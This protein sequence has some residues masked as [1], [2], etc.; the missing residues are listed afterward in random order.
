MR[1]LNLESPTARNA[2]VRWVGE[3]RAVLAGDVRGHVALE[4]LSSLPHLYGLGPLEGLRGE[5]SIFGDAPSLAHVE[6]GR[7][8]TA[9]GWNA[10]SCFLVWA[11][12]PQ[13]SNH[14]M[15]S[16]ASLDAVEGEARRLAAEEGPGET[17]PFPFKILGLAEEI[18]FH[19]LDK[20]DGPGHSP[21]RH[22]LAKAR[23]TLERTPVELVGFHS[24]QHRGIFTPKESNIHVHMRTED[25][26][27]SGHVETIRLSAGARIS[28][29][30]R[31]WP[32]QTGK[33][34]L[35]G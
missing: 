6:Q 34:H 14:T 13:W 4:C 2:G 1:R 26:R 20:R 35:C 7:V 19:V 9:S 32:H 33:E 27:I 21:E 28:V 22:E 11:Q 3:Q 30:S 29:P 10:R 25:G 31:G 16:V 18:T 15:A 17:A 12:V 5:V 23:W 24:R 8:V